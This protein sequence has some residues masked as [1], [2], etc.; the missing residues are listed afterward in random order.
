M[1]CDLTTGCFQIPFGI[2]G[3]LTSPTHAI[4]DSD[5]PQ[6]W[7][8]RSST[9][10]LGLTTNVSI[11]PTQ[12][13]I[14]YSFESGLTP[15]EA[16][17]QVIL[18]GMVEGEENERRFKKLT[19]NTVS[20]SGNDPPASPST[21]ISYS[22]YRFAHLAAFEFNAISQVSLQTASVHADIRTSGIN[23]NVFVLE[24]RSNWGG[25]RTGLS[26]VRIHGNLCSPSI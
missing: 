3:I 18:W 25:K 13:T 23:F 20:F 6:T 24:I 12:T 1:A 11:C 22:R 19:Q 26:R 2:P 5:P 17:R 21:G 16:P 14:E 10:Q 8:F 7:R 15:D 9:G 4:T